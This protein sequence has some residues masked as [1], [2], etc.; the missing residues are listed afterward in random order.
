MALIV[1]ATVRIQLVLT[2]AVIAK[3]L[4]PFERILCLGTL[5][6]KVTTQIRQSEAEAIKK[7]VLFRYSLYRINKYKPVSN[8]KTIGIA[9]ANDVF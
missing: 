2:N 4:R 9:M 8:S 1:Q 3:S 7:E 5:I 6:K